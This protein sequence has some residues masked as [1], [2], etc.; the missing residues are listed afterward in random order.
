M[1]LGGR[2]CELAAMAT[3]SYDVGRRCQRAG[4]EPGGPASSQDCRPVSELRL[5]ASSV[6]PR[7]VVQTTTTEPAYRANSSAWRG[8]LCETTLRSLRRQDRFGTGSGEKI[9]YHSSESSR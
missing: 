5:M 9:R 2:S 8:T 6:S 3:T 4:L 1:T 7:G